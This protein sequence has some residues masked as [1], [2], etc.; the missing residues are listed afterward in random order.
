MHALTVTEN[1]TVTHCHR[2]TMQ[3]VLR[4]SLV[5]GSCC[6]QLASCVLSLRSAPHTAVEL[7]CIGDT[8]GWPCVCVACVAC[9]LAAVCARYSD[10]S[11]MWAS[12][13]CK[14]LSMPV[15]PRQCHFGCVLVGIARCMSERQGWG[16]M[17][18][19]ACAHC[20]RMSLSRTVTVPRCKRS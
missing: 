8:D 18:W 10:V 16:W 2:L 17:S 5:K 6:G 7:C 13:V 14:Y 3:K 11:E 12:L 9:G 4:S 1:I 15:C 19:R 20:H